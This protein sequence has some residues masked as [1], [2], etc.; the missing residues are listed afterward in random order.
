[1]RRSAMRGH[2]GWSLELAP[3]TLLRGGVAARVLPSLPHGTRLYLPS[4]PSDPPD[5]IERALRLMR[6]A[7]RAITPVP[8]IA[9]SRVTSEAELLRTLDTWQAAT[10]NH[11]SEVLIVRGDPRAHSTEAGGDGA[12]ECDDRQDAA[13]TSAAAFSESLE[14]VESG[15]LQ[16]RGISCTGLCGHPEGVGPLS[17]EAALQPLLAKVRAAEKGGMGARV[18]TQFC[19]DAGRSTDYVDS[20]RAAG[21]LSPVSVGVVGPAPTATLARM[22]RQCGVAPPHVSANSPTDAHAAGDDDD[23]AASG[24]RW[25][26][27][28]VAHL[29]DWQGERGSVRGFA[30]LHLY[31]FGG[32]RSTLSWL[33]AEAAALGLDVPGELLRDADAD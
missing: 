24:A 22:A 15:L 19:F 30:D 33:G 31:P 18:V 23:G 13:Q 12:S 6:E 29:R 26:G 1:M 17:A 10:S 20:L 16:A 25:P 5:A 11:L 27:R 7:N 4:L 8:H 32:V 9:A 28:Y 2:P 14:V 3:M 21:I